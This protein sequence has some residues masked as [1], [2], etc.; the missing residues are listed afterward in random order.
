MTAQITTMFLLFFA[1]WE[2][3]SS[4]LFTFLKFFFM[5]CVDLSDFSTFLLSC[6]VFI[7]RFV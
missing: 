5:K 7:L 2:F 6:D 4:T 1:F 3:V